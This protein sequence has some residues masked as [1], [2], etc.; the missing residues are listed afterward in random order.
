MQQASYDSADVRYKVSERKEENTEINMDLYLKQMQE[1]N[2][3]KLESAKKKE[4]KRRKSSEKR[5]HSEHRSD[6]RAGCNQPIEKTSAVLNFNQ[7]T[8]C[9]KPMRNHSANPTPKNNHL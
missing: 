8:G 7:N 4:Q 5:Q 3:E 9:P 2:R 1:R 6:N